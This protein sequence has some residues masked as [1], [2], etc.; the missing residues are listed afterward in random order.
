MPWVLDLHLA[1]APVAHNEL[2][3]HR[4]TILYHAV[5]AILEC[6]SI[7]WVTQ[8]QP[9]LLWLG[10]QEP[11]PKASEHRIV[12]LHDDGWHT[13]NVS[14]LIS[15][16]FSFVCCLDLFD[17]FKLHSNHQER[18]LGC[19]LFRTWIFA[20]FGKVKKLQRVASFIFFPILPSV[21]A[22]GR[23]CNSWDWEHPTCEPAL[24]C[25]AC[26][27]KIPKNLHQ[28]L[29]WRF[30]S[31]NSEVYN[32]GI[33]LYLFCIHDIRSSAC[34]HLYPGLSELLCHSFNHFNRGLS[35]SRFFKKETYNRTAAYLYSTLIKLIYKIDQKNGTINIS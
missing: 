27:E 6:L 14:V 8:L 33:C 10:C 30:S 7:V 19:P 35:W 11:L 3:L 34:H 21:A 20:S 32:T 17:L 16:P 24:A 1:F 23:S 12:W 25:P 9:V 18:E 28:Q 22:A 5:L 15:C 4:F 2:D 26:P 13:L 31:V 29:I